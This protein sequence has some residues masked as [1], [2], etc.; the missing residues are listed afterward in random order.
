MLYYIIGEV[1]MD[2]KIR[3]AVNY[4]SNSSKLENMSLSQDEIMQI[5][6]DIK[7]GK[8]DKSFLYSLVEAVKKRESS[9]NG[10]GK[11]L[12]KNDGHRQHR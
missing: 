3:E 4:A 9:L 1:S 8:S 6:N 12:V 11:A 7:N 2:E 10:Q 5:I